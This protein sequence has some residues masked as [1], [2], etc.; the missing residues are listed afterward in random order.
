MSQSTFY[1]KPYFLQNE[2]SETGINFFLQSN[3]TLSQYKP[4]LPPEYLN[5]STITKVT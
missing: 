2:I 1:Q 3:E 4:R 5:I